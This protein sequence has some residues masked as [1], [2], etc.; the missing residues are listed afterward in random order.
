[1]AFVEAKLEGDFTTALDR[2]AKEAAEA[3]IYSGAAQA[4]RVIYAEVK[5]NTT[6]TRPKTPGI[7]TGNLTESIY[8]AKDTN[9]ST[10]TRAVYSIS[11]NKSKAPHG[12]WL[13]FG[14]SRMPAL[15]FVR[16]AMSQ[17]DEAVKQGLARMKV[18]YQE[19]VGVR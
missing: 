10:Q 13:E 11:W 7:V 18:R 15:P 9:A 17:M 1:M 16:P 14:N 19:F 12:H 2:L 3:I 4:A 6:G 8:W 5:L